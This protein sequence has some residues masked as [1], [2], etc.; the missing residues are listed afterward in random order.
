MQVSHLRTFIALVEKGGFSAAAQYLRISQPAVSQQIQRLED[1]LRV[2]LLRRD[3]R[4]IAE[5][6]PCGEMV[7]DFA[8]Q[9]SVA[10]DALQNDLARQRGAIEGKLHLAASTT[11]G[12]YLVPQWVA[13]FCAQHPHVEAVVTVGD[14]ASVVDQL[15]TGAYDMGFVGAP[16]ERPGLCLERLATDEVVLAVYP[17]HPFLERDRVTWND[18]LTQPLIVR[19]EGSGTQQ[20]VNHLLSERELAL[21]PQSVSLTLGSTQAVVQAIR[22]RLG[23]GFVSR[24]AVARVPQ[25]EQLPTVRIEGLAFARQ[26][27][28][29][30]DEKRVDSPLTQAFLA[31]LRTQSAV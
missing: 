29:A 14:T 9:V 11:P 31:F 3:R 12:E 7:L 19:E 6:T 1:E 17:G 21:E 13:R 23:I 2:T 8:R 20:T 10:Y 27:Y 16:I 18:V 22:D 26:I 28:V 4:G 5:V 24:R 15:S 30:Y 25:A